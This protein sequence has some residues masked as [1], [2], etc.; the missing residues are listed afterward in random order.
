M[1]FVKY[2]S[3]FVIIILASGCLEK[4]TSM[5]KQE[6]IIY[7]NVTVEERDL[8]MAKGAYSI[9]DTSNMTVVIAGIE[10]YQGEITRLFPPVNKLAKKFPAIY[11]H[12][13]D[14]GRKIGL[15]SGEDYHGPGVYNFTIEF[16]KEVNKSR[17]IIILVEALNETG[18]DMYYNRNMQFNWSEEKQSKTFK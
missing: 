13:L 1:R 4:V 11:V 3:L 10:A 16:R 12:V 18:Y 14:G 8:S 5:G 15:M 17:P 2:I 9:N 6:P 7:V